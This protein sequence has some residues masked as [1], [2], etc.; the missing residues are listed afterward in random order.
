MIYKI[1]I[2]ICASAIFVILGKKYPEVQKIKNNDLNSYKRTKDI[3]RSGSMSN[4]KRNYF[5]KSNKSLLKFWSFSSLLKYFKKIPEL[6]S[7]FKDKTSR[8]DVNYQ[9]PLNLGNDINYKTDE[10]KTN[11]NLSQFSSSELDSEV[12]FY[13]AD[14]LFD[15]GKLEQAEKSYIEIASKYPKNS[16]VYNRLGAIYLEQKNFC[17]AKEAFGE[18]IKQDDSIASRHFNYALACFELGES[19]E[20]YRSIRR[21]LELDPKNKKYHDYFEQIKR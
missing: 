20:A 13:H 4:I 5:I 8:N 2:F 15:Q 1:I 12:L 18:L 3:S 7:Y 21:A 16:K 11:D 10:N 6:F 9:N 17:D 19:D 14:K